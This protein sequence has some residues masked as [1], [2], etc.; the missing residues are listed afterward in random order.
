MTKLFFEKKS[1]SKRNTE[2]FFDENN[3]QKSVMNA[4]A[5]WYRGRVV[6]ITALRPGSVIKDSA[7]PTLLRTVKQA[8]F[9][10]TNVSDFWQRIEADSHYCIICLELPNE[11]LNEIPALLRRLFRLSEFKTKAGRMG[12]VIR[13]SRAGIWYYQVR[14]NIVYHLSSW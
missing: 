3:H 9:I 12:K 14:D 10:T 1:V 5:A 2:E 11:R 13:V 7:I 8:T 6:S 4:V